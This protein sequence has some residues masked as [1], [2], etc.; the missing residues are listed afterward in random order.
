[1]SPDAFIQMAIQLAYYRMNKQVCASYEAVSQRMFRHGRVSLLLSTTSVSAAFVKAFDDPEKQ[2]TEKIDLLQK[3]I[4]THKEN[5]KVVTGGHDIV[6][7]IIAL[8]LQ[9]V[10]NKIPMPDIFRDISYKKFLNYQLTTSQVKI[11]LC[12]FVYVGEGLMGK[13]DISHQHMHVIK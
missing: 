1:M 7:H 9:A 2:N 8:S 4:K 10:E 11:H 3:A 12:C 13:T 6:A 5:I